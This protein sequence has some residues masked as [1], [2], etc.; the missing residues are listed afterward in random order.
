MKIGQLLASVKTLQKLV[1]QPL[2]L[3]QAYQLSKIAN[4]VNTELNFFETK[5]DQILNSDLTEEEKM[6]KMNEL[7]NFEVDWDVDP[8]V[9]KFDDNILLSAF[10]LDS[11]Q[12]MI[13]IEE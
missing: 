7:I 6:E 11:C 10:E 1:E 3:R 4:K 8:V 9:F 12:G 13:E 2:H 5:R